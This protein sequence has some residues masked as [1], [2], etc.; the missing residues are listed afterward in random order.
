M[1]I[2]R[3][4]PSANTTRTKVPAAKNFSR[5]KSKQWAGDER[6]SAIGKSVGQMSALSTPHIR[7]TVPYITEKNYMNK[8]SLNVI[9]RPIYS[10]YILILLLAI[11]ARTTSVHG[12]L[13][14]VFS[15]YVI[16]P[17]LQ[18]PSRTLIKRRKTKAVRG[19]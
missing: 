4:R 14:A 5:R 6:P 11:R 17:R 18:T 15:F 1:A 8:T 19:P 16:S 7:P 2:L 13:T 3:Q 9:R 12:P 10:S